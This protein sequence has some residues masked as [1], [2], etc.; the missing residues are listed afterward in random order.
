MKNALINLLKVKTI[1]TLAITG[2]FVYLAIIGKLPVETTTMVIGMVF[3][4]YFNKK[5]KGDDTNGT[6]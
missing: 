5:D 2:V 6:N 4:Y 3:T 1:I